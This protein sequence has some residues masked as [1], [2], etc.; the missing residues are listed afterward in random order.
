[1][2]KKNS[3]S[4]LEKSKKRN[5][6]SRR[7][8]V[9]QIFCTKGKIYTFEGV[10]KKEG[11]H[12][13]ES[14][15]TAHSRASLIVVDGI[16][17][18]IWD[19]KTLKLFLK[20]KNRKNF[21]IVDL[22]V[23][24]IYPGFVECHTHLIYAG[25]RADE[26]NWRLEGQSY[27]EISAKGGGILSTVKALEKVTS[28]K[29]LKDSQEKVNRF[30]AQ[31]VTT[32]EVK[33]G[34]GLSQKEELRSLQVAKNL[35]GPHIVPTYLGAHSIPPLYKGKVGE[36]IREVALPTAQKVLQKKLAK[37]ADIF[38]EKGFFE[39]ET[40]RDYLQKLKAMGFDI[41]LHAD[42]LTRTGASLLGAEMGALSVDHAIQINDSDIQAL[43]R[44]QTTAV[45]LPSAD[46][47]MRCAYPPARKLMDEG[48]RV[49]LAT[50]YNPGTSPTQDLAFTGLLARMEM[51][52]SLAE[53]FAAYTY[54]GAAALALQ[55]SQGCLLPGYAAN[56]FTSHAE[57]SEFFYRVGYTPVEQV[58]TNGK[59]CFTKNK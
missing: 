35:Q 26:F 44:S 13:Q 39:I 12:I 22:G 16:I 42:Q 43:T 37:R 49:A 10:Q 55:K 2:A 18:E 47:Y 30:L 11:R 7:K 32:L 8:P 54:N 36:Y 58:Y 3:A 45:L 14:D 31:G 15:L 33:S 24:H 25:N 20:S 6:K 1:M 19:E 56:F 41:I 48:V 17:Q 23:T 29:L 28:K 57:P 5:T 52:M 9:N 59:I 46:F 51:K 50:D 38:V 34:Y 53:V 40:A 4:S 27:Q 21:R